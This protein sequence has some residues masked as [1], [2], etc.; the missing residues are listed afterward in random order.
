MTDKKNGR[1]VG[2]EATVQ[3]NVRQAVIDFIN[4]EDETSQIWPWAMTAEELLQN[5]EA[6]QKI[7][8]A[9]EHD[10]TGECDTDELYDAISRIAGVNPILR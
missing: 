7:V 4:F 10:G 3:E 8:K 2:S 5:E 6:L 9:V 1:D